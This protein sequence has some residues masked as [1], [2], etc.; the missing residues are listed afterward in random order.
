MAPFIVSV[1]ICLLPLVAGQVCPFASENKRDIADQPSLITLGNSFGK[2]P[3]ISDAAGGGSRSKDWWPRQL[4]LDVLRQFS[5][6]QNPLGGNFDYAAAFATLDC[7][8]ITQ[9]V[10][11][12]YRNLTQHRQST[13]IR[14]Q[15]YINTVAT[16]VASRFWQLWWSVYSFSMAQC[17]HLS[18]P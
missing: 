18:G 5:P 6:E 11:I 10:G 1:L 4:R 8:I 15:H 16:V 7:K 2:S 12:K 14:Y 3:I 17:R 13:Q 9:M